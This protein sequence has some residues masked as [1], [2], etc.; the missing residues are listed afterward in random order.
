MKTIVPPDAGVLGAMMT[1]RAD[2]LRRSRLQA[3]LVQSSLRKP[4]RQA[5]TPRAVRG[6]SASG[7]PVAFASS[8]PVSRILRVTAR[9]ATL[10]ARPVVMSGR[11]RQPTGGTATTLSTRSA[12]RTPAARASNV[13][14]DAISKRSSVVGPV[15]AG[16]NRRLPPLQTVAR[17]LT[18]RSSDRQVSTFAGAG[19]GARARHSTPAS[20]SAR[21][22]RP[23][24]ALAAQT[25]RSGE[26]GLATASPTRSQA[27]APSRGSA[28]AR[29]DAGDGGDNGSGVIVLAGDVLVDGRR[30]GELAVISAARTGSSAQTAARSPNFRST[31]LPSGLS[32]PLP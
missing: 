16:G 5:P 30:M 15:L 12:G 19:S 27:G 2:R 20:Q 32:A 11:I 26:R 6:A 14:A 25:G 9:P 23:A 8:R 21:R 28:R 18:K 4:T 29:A 1:A 24:A 13:V 17:E 31:A 3:E 22:S 7:A 10:V